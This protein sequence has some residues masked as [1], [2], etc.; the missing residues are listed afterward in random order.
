VTQAEL[1]IESNSVGK[2][3]D[4][5]RRTFEVV[6]FWS[7]DRFSREG[8]LQTLQH[9]NTLSS[10]GIGYRSLTEPYLDSCGIFKEAI[11]DI[12]GTVAKQERRRISDRVSAG[13]RRA[14]LTGTRSGRPIGRPRVIFDRAKA[15]QLRLEGLSWRQIA[16][17]SVSRSHRSDAAFSFEAT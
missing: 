10:H 17:G 9:M 12:L 8:A 14:R 11:I 2:M 7:L 5:V 1:E 13:L 15:T 4:A 6:V 16:I 3:Q